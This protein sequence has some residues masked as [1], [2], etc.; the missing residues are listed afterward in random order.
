[1]GLD[2]DLD[3][4]RVVAMVKVR[5][6]GTGRGRRVD[7]RRR[8]RRVRVSMGIGGIM[9]CAMGCLGGASQS[10]RVMG[11]GIV[12]LAG[13]VFNSQLLYWAH[14]FRFLRL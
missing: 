13:D 8:G 11:A 2:L 3:L 9:N 10:L 14:S 6:A 4:R 12:R 7:V 1:M 5:D